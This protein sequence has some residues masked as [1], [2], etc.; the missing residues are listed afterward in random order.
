MTTVTI[1]P[2]PSAASYRAS[3]GPHQSTG[4]TPGE[5]LDALNAQ[6][7]SNGEQVVR[8]FQPDEF[9]TADQCRRLDELMTRWRAARDAGVAMPDA[10][11]AELDALID[12][13]LDAATLRAARRGP[14]P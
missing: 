13:E 6:L 8:Q 12:A 7:T 4:R 11:R 1:I 2:D 9:F 10:E 5:A 3:A 14:T